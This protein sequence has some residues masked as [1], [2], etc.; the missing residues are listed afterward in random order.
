[1][2]RLPMIVLTAFAFV[3]L[4]RSSGAGEMHRTKEDL[5]A[6]E[7]TRRPDV[8]IWNRRGGH[9]NWPAKVAEHWLIQ[10]L[11]VHR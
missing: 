8:A 1:M 11:T 9:G 10:G 4:H 7:V 6:L 5:E 3:H 2:K